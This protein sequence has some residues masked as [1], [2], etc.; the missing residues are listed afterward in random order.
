[1]GIIRGTHTSP[2]IYT[3]I[4][5][6]KK[7]SKTRI[8]LIGNK[9]GDMSHIG[10]GGNKPIV[11]KY[12]T[13]TA[14]EDNCAIGFYNNPDS[15]IEPTIEYSFDKKIWNTLTEEKINIAQNAN[16]YCRGI[17]PDGIS[18]GYGEGGYNYFIGEGKFNVSGDIMSLIDYK[19]MPETMVGTFYNLF[20]GEVEIVDAS[21]LVLSAKV[22]TSYCYANMFDSCTSMVYGPKIEATTLSQFCYYKM[23]YNCTSLTTAPELPVNKLE[24]ECY[25]YMFYDCKSLTEATELPATTLADSCYYDMFCG[26]TSLTE[27]PELP[28]TTLAEH[29]YSSMFEGCTNLTQTPELPATTLANSCYYGMFYD[30]TS[31]TE[32]P[33]L[34]ATTLA[35]SCYY[36]MFMGCTS[37]TEAPELPATTLADSCYGLMFYNCTSLT[38]APELPATTLAE[39]CYEY[40]FY[41]CTSLT[42]VP[43]ELPAT[44]LYERCYSYMFANCTGLTKAPELPATTLAEYCYNS[45]FQGCTSLTE[46]PELPATTLVDFCYNTMFFNCTSLNYIKCLSTDMF[47]IGSTQSWVTM[48]SSTG[49]FVAHPDAIWSTGISGIPEDWVVEEVDVPYLIFRAQEDNSSIGLENLSPN[50]SLWYSDSSDFATSHDFNT[51]TN[52][53]LNNGDKV[54]VRGILSADNTSSNYTQFKMSGKIAAS[55]NCNALWNYEDLNATLQEYCGFSMF[56]GCT[57]LT[58]APELAATTLSKSCYKQMFDACTSLTKAPELPATEGLSENCY[59]RMFRNCTSLMEAPELPAAVVFKKSYYE[60]FRGCES[61]NIIKCLAINI[62]ADECTENWVNDVSSEGTFIKHPDT[63]WY[64]G[65]DGIPSGWVVEDAVLQSI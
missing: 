47:A 54:Y 12:L 1:M 3:Q 9:I 44:E 4:T 25:A 59:E 8:T 11:N 52:I 22:L 24:K 29:C 35:D 21:K 61:L 14:L 5:D 39:R 34:P 33:E 55:G 36:D 19:T 6:I 7:Q 16:M 23:F 15:S 20:G 62:D 58:Q 45:M 63:T 2:G 37:L 64:T 48:V 40:M 30:C 46:A 32:A 43:D 26:C 53:S 49:T 57:S 41:D 13:F 51:T 27:A 60:M 18:G 42:Q 65:N 17:N 38:E 10:T 28:A 50:Q 31:L 56:E